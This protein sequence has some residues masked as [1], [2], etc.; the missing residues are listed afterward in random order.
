MSW[1]EL[2]LEAATSHNVYNEDQLPEVQRDDC[3]TMSRAM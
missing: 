1:E 2:D 3:M